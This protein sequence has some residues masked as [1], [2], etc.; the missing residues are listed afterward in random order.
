MPPD[1]LIHI[2]GTFFARREN[3]ESRIHERIVLNQVLENS[4]GIN[5]MESFLFID[6][7]GK[8]CILS[9]ISIFSAK[10]I[11]HGSVEDFRKKNCLLIMKAD[12]IEGMGEMVGVIDR[13]DEISSNAQLLSVI[14]VFDQDAIPPLYKMWIGECLETLA[15][16]RKKKT[17]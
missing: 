13:V 12:S 3:V 14:I 4:M 7:N 17:M 5:P 6:G 1:D 16:H 10:V 9:E 15:R 11:I 8:K 2:I